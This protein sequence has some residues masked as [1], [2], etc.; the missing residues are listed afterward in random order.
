MHLDPIRPL[1]EHD[2]PFVSVS[3]DVSRDTEDARQQADARVT[4]LRHELERRGVSESLRDELAARLAEVPHLPGEVRRSIV[5]ADDEVIFDD[6]VMGGTRWPQGVEV[7]PLPQL[8][9]WATQVDGEFAFLLV[10]ADRAGAD[11]D[12]HVAMNRPAAEHKEV[13]GSTLHINKV[14]EGDWAQKQFQRRSEN[15]WAANAKLV[16]E[17]VR[18]AESRYRPSLVV[19]AGD[20]RARTD[21][22][23]ALAGLPV[24]VEQIESGG[25]GAGAS[26]Q[27]MWDDV[28]RLVA[29]YEADAEQDIAERL[30]RGTATGSGA[31]R[32]L[33]GVLDALVRGE[34]DTLVADLDAAHEMSVRPDHHPG[35]ALPASAVDADELPA[36]QVLLAAGAATGAQLSVLPRELSHGAGVAAL[37]RWDE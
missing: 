32:G 3:A 12:V 1:L 6:A 5:A 35:L 21:L 11:M 13:H 31:V 20:V 23:D 29:R 16:A 19:L 8:S 15:L 27:S 25:R 10:V 26:D 37:L 17:R 22:A 9:G 18:S 33:E 14:P 2:G 36:D 24:P 4:T 30:E 28:R 34:V 7:G